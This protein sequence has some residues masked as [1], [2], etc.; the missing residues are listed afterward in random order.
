MNARRGASAER[1]RTRPSRHIPVLLSQVLRILSPRA[2]ETYIDATF[3]AGGYTR[4]ILAAAP[5]CRVLAIDRDPQAVTG[6]GGLLEEFAGRLT[7][8]AGRFSE[9]D[10]IAEGAGLAPAHGVLLDVGVSSLQIDSPERGFSF[11]HDGPLDMRMS[12]TGPSAADVVNTLSETKLAD[13]LYQLG[14]ERRSRAI[15][16][17]IV[18][19]RRERP[20]S[21]TLELAHLVERVLGRRRGEAQHPAMRTFLALRI[22]VNDELT[23]LW[24]GLSAAERVLA[25]GG[26]LIAVT[27]HSLEHGLVKRFLA[28]RTGRSARPS[29]HTPPA[30]EM[31]RQAS[32]RFVNHR[33]ISPSEQEIAANP[34]ARSAQLRAA[35]RTEAPVWPADRK[36]LGLPRL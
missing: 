32:F 9:L 34:R 25:P 29:R 14:E 19:R 33:P 6:G 26:R 31:A 8:V 16:R 30:Q 10:R 1:M 11:Q 18:A 28:E 2:G 22:Y 36:E 27:F 13:V 35:L 21:R 3:G 12:G 5:G 20:F 24:G 15:A 4:A 23:E 17:A 7:L